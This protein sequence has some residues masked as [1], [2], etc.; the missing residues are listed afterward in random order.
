[1]KKLLAAELSAKEDEYKEYLKDLEL[2]GKLP[3]GVFGEKQRTSL[4]A[5]KQAILNQMGE[6][7]VQEIKD[8]WFFGEKI[9]DMQISRPD[10]TYWLLTGK[11]DWSNAK[12]LKDVT[13]IIEISSSDEKNSSKTPLDK[14]MAPYIKALAIIAS[15]SSAEESPVTISIYSCKKNKKEISKRI[16][17]YT[18]DKAREMLQNVYNEAFGEA[19]FSKCVPVTMLEDSFS[20]TT[21]YEFRDKLQDEHGPWAYFDKKNLFNP[22][23]DIGYTVEGFKEEWEH[24]VNKMKQL[25]AFS[26]EQPVASGNN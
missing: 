11:L 3:N 24:A 19:K 26:R 4:E 25:T 7:R 14:F 5:K 18:P 22:I 1:M 9:P 23:T 12:E 8:K 13:E 2:K 16:V 20:Y 10:G 17:S 6:Q 15:K 21:I